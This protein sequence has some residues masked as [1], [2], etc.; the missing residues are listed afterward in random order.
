MICEYL[1][2]CSVA[3]YKSR[4]CREEPSK[5]ELCDGKRLY[6]KWVAQDEQML[7]DHAKYRLVENK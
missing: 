2:Y 1:N 5:C 4:L 6:E 3:D 7:K